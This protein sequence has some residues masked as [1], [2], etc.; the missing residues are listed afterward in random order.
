MSRRVLLAFCIAVVASAL[1]ASSTNASAVL[2]GDLG[3]YAARLERIFDGHLP[4]LD[5]TFE[6]LPFSLVPLLAARALAGVPRIGLDL[7]LAAVNAL[8]LAGVL[9]YSRRI[10]HALGMA[11]VPQRWLIAAAPL[12]PI[13]L[14]RLDPLSLLC[15]AVA[16]FGLVEGRR[17]LTGVSALVGALARGWPV[18]FA[19]EEWRAGWR[20]LAILTMAAIGFVAAWL[21][22]TPGFTAGRAFSG[23]QI[24]TLVGSLLLAGGHMTGDPAV[25]REAAGSLYVGPDA[26]LAANTLVGLGVIG[27]TIARLRRWPDSVTVLALGVYGLLLVSP[28][29]S[30]QMLLWPTIFVAAL[31]RAPLRLVAVTGLTTT[32]LLTAWDPNTAW[33]ALVLVVRNTAFL[34]T[35]LLIARRAGGAPSQPS[36]SL[37]NLPV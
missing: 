10:G 21:L 28:L 17:V 13:V 4:Y 25:I 37:R 15:A 8:L 1:L 16:L 6:H 3:T 27:L 22:T 14:Y 2:Q 36:I 19:I 30:A 23:V 9:I 29:L 7:A 33:W 20:R 18:V 12:F 35:P 32:L 26:A 31:P 11:S 34:A 24:E 5:A